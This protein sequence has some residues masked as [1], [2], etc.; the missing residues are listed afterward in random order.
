MQKLL[1]S[2]VVIFVCSVFGLAQASNSALNAT[3]EK[4]RT[5]RGAD[6]KLLTITAAEHAARGRIYLE[7]RHF[8]ESREHFQ[9][10]IDNFP[11]D[12]AVSYAL[13]GMGRS[14]MWEREYAKAAVWFDR[15]TR[16]F[17]A[18][19]DGR[20]SLYFQASCYIR[21]YK[22]TE[23]AP[24][25]ERY[26]VMY[27]SGERIDT[28]YL[29]LI[30]AFREA[31]QYENSIAWVDKTRS[32][33]TGTPTE[34]NAMQAKLRM[35]IFR[36]NWTGAVSA[37]D[38]ILQLDRFADSMTSAD[39]IKYLR[40]Y[41]I[42]RSGKKAEAD[43]AFSAIADNNTYFGGLAAEKLAASGSRVKRIVLSMPNASKDF[44]APYRN[45]I[46]EYA[47][48]KRLDPRFILAIMK[49]ESTFRPSIQSASAARGL[50]QLVIDTALKYNKRAGF[51]VIKPDDLYV[52]RI[53]IAI[54]CEY[55]AALRDEF[56]G[57][58]E[59]IAAS[60]NGGEDN[61]ARWLARAK[62]KDPGVFASE[63]GFA[64]TKNYVFKV[65]T[66]YRV[67]RELY[68]VNLVRPK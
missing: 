36:G 29:N 56:G 34:I 46:L 9:K 16:D 53:N 59:A 12:P 64:E 60:Y 48:K 45:E 1:R 49:Q 58:N 14:L 7:N 28:A 15:A 65:M 27:P 8:P 25:F 62:S 50:L 47:R 18:T 33:F 41:S 22:P 55:I 10:I 21:T 52:P 11:A 63:V 31:K 6:G 54:G 23:A 67:Y 57:L 35:E 61:A 38:D 2:F 68:D 30:D 3:I 32:R 19:K 42:E 40:A 51:P 39:E 43:T 66:N 20:E 5:S 13:F 4:D 44:P 24:L 37:A 26:T 17:P